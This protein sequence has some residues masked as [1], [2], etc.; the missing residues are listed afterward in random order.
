MNSINFVSPTTFG[1]ITTYKCSAQCED[2]CFSCSPQNN[3]RISLA[4]LKETIKKV[5]QQV[6][7][8]V[9]VFTGCETTLL[10]Q[11]LYSALTYCR[12]L[13]LTTR[14]ITNGFWGYSP[15]A[16]KTKLDKLI[17]SGLNELNLSTGDNHQKFVPIDNVMN[18][19]YEAVYRGLPTLISVEKAKGFRFDLLDLYNHPTYSRIQ[20]LE[21]NYLFKAMS[22]PWV[23]LKNPK[24]YEYDEGCL[25]TNQLGCNSLFENITIDADG[26]IYSC[27]GLTVREIPEFYVGNISENFCDDLSYINQEGYDKFFLIKYWIYTDGPVNII[28]KVKDWCPDIIIPEFAHQCLYCQAIFNNS[29]IREVIEKNIGNIRDEILE[30]FHNKVNFL[31]QFKGV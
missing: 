31:N 23:S 15:K 21:N 19:S 1:I 8:K 25:A 30:K 10:G 27:C 26:K 17:A 5:A 14:I 6:P 4:E 7:I 9:V 3:S 2:C 28:R 11:D 29:T 13:G 22:S 18:I 20:S 24:K 16:I 12:E